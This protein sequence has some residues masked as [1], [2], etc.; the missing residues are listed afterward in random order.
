MIARLFVLLPFSLTVPE[1]EQFTIYEYPDQSYSVRVFP[2]NRSDRLSPLDGVDEIRMDGVPAFQA[3][4]LRI[5]FYQES[6]NRTTQNPCDPLEDVIRRAINSF[7]I[8]LRYVAHAAQVRPLDHPFTWRIRYLNDD[9]T[10]LEIDENLIRGRGGLQFSFSWIGLN[11]QVWE[12]IQDL[13]PD[14]EPP[15]WEE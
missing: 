15:P 9:E 1:G 7:L 11:K 13:P 8:R 12:D 10:E 14:Y 3:D 5:D 6:F 2:P 4:A